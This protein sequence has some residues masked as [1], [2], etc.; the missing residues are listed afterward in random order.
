MRA[1][2]LKHGTVFLEIDGITIRISANGAVDVSPILFNALEWEMATTHPSQW[3]Y[4]TEG[5]ARALD[6]DAF[7]KAR[8]LANSINKSLGR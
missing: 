8:A 2:K 3:E 4:L 5:E 1:I 7:E 6:G